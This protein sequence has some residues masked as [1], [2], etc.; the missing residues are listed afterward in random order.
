MT[1]NLSAWSSP[2]CCLSLTLLLSSNCC[3]VSSGGCSSSCSSCCCCSGV[4]FR[5]NASTPIC[6]LLIVN[7]V[8]VGT[9]DV[10]AVAVASFPPL[11]ISSGSASGASTSILSSIILGEPLLWRAASILSSIILEESSLGESLLWPF[12][13]GTRAMPEA[14]PV[15]IAPEPGC[16]EDT[17]IVTAKSLTQD[18]LQ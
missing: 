4:L 11:P 2:C 17:I 18:P 12:I 1:S 13:K 6:E 7:D 3:D 16:S 8:D 14:E 9:S 5:S 15:V 10:S